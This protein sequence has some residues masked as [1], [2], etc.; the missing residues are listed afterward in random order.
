MAIQIRGCRME[1]RWW[2]IKKGETESTQ[3]GREA[4]KSK[5]LWENCRD[6]KKK[7]PSPEGK[8][9]GKK[10]SCVKR[11]SFLQL[12]VFHLGLRDAS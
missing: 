2:V 7:N 12:L 4:E 6:K 11:A 10:P 9:G 5:E 1:K 3:N 8:T